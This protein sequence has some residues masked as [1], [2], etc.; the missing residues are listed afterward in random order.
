MEKGDKP[1]SI[2]SSKMKPKD[3][4]AKQKKPLMKEKKPK[5][6]KPAKQKQK[7][8]QK[9]ENVQIV[10]V[11]VNT[12][13]E[14]KPPLMKPVRKEITKQTTYVT[15]DKPYALQPEEE[16]L[17]TITKH[18]P[19]P[20]RDK[21]RAKVTT[22]VSDPKNEIPQP[23]I[24]EQPLQ[25]PVPIPVPIKKKVTA[26]KKGLFD[27]PVEIFVGAKPAIKKG[28]DILKQ[29]KEIKD[30]LIPEPEPQPEIL[31]VKPQKKPSAPLKKKKEPK[32]DVPVEIFVGAKPKKAKTT[33]D[34]QPLIV[35]ASKSLKKVKEIIPSTNSSTIDKS[36][37]NSS[38]NNNEK[39]QEMLIAEPTVSE[40]QTG[41]KINKNIK[42]KLALKVE[43]VEE[44]IVK[45]RTP[46]PTKIEIKKQ[47]L[48][49]I[50]SEMRDISTRNPLYDGLKEQRNNLIDE[51][52]M[53]REIK[54]LSTETVPKII[55][56][57]TMEEILTKIEKPDLTTAA[58][59]EEEVY[60]Y[61]TNSDDANISNPNSGE[62]INIQNETELEEEFGLSSA[63]LESYKEDYVMMPLGSVQG[64]VEQIEKKSSR[65]RP[66]KYASE[67]ER[68]QA[69]KEQKK[70]SA[71]KIREDKKKEEKLIKQM[72][73]DIQ[74]EQFI[75]GDYP[76]DSLEEM[77]SKDIIQKK[78]NE[79]AFAEAMVNEAYSASV[80]GQDLSK[81][82]FDPFVGQDIIV[83]PKIYL[84]EG[85]VA[86]SKEKPDIGEGL[87]SDFVSSLVDKLSDNNNYNSNQSAQEEQFDFL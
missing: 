63:Q 42:P 66:S 73:T 87:S 11:N 52:D 78:Q 53:L 23:N 57:Q 35:E 64:L 28:I 30:I 65:G 33:E 14:E 54:K 60:D 5:D 58:S 72:E 49:K 13:K 1:K 26:K 82:T 68:L 83:S 10:K 2:T 71:I 20:P 16:E 74:Y 85:S 7:Q 75:Q 34:E 76:P 4:V 56:K 29:V 6:K 50:E 51:I 70:A 43:Q 44:E 47:E 15:L 9:Q 19:N 37:Q 48:R 22:L 25:I 79:Q 39:L 8:K 18:V 38:I 41:L 17:L 59:L 62:K 67:E 80:G 45:E 31:M 12:S 24:Q 46:I 40:K 77:L 55:V 84:T 21:S 81:I 86:L 69:I 27:V 32:Y 61:I 3:S 36:I